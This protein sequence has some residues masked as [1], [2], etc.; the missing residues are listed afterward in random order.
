MWPALS[1]G[2]PSGR[3]E[4]VYNIE[5]FNAAVRQG[6]WKLL[7]KAVL[8]SKIE[9]FNIAEDPNEKTNLAVQQPDK[10]KQLQARI[11]KLAGEA[12]QPLFMAAA[13]NAIFGGLFGPAPIPTEDD[14][15]TAEP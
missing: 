6:D 4:L 5:P 8:P 12:V 10:V 13:T 11:E 14:S 7:W 9:L 3:N 1:E 2:K 15:N